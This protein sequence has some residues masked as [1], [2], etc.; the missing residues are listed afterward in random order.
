MDTAVALDTFSGNTELGVS[1]PVICCK[2]SFQNRQF[3]PV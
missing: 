3:N 1:L 2:T